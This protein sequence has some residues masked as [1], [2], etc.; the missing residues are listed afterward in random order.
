M[1]LSL[2][3]SQPAPELTRQRN[4]GI[5]AAKGDV[6]VSCEDD[7]VL[8]RSAFA[9][10]REA[11]EDEPVVGATVHLVERTERSVGGMSKGAWPALKGDCRA[12]APNLSERPRPDEFVRALARNVP[13]VRFAAVALL[14][15]SQT[16]GRP[17]PLGGSV[18]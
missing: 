15:F 5:A 8:D 9:A 2:R 4:A 1:R 16:V 6:I 7:I 18:L 13:T 17:V 10:L 12:N 11:Y 3:S 14:R